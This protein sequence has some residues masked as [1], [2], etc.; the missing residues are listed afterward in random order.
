[1]RESQLPV[2]NSSGNVRVADNWELTVAP[3]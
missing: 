1:V 3:V 2:A